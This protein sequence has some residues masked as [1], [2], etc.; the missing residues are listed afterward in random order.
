MKFGMNMQSVY[1]R[2]CTKLNDNC[3][4][5]GAVI[6]CIPTPYLEAHNSAHFGCLSHLTSLF[7]VL[8]S[9]LKQADEL[10]LVCLIWKMFSVG[11]PPGKG[12]GNTAII[13]KSV[14]LLRLKQS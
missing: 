6:Q 8:E 12:L 11:V 2:Q 1:K 10:I 9:L 13:N 4:H 14:S 7:L 5:G 3:P